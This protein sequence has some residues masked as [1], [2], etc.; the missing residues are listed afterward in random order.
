MTVE[1][2]MKLDMTATTMY[3]DNV[4]NNLNAPIWK[5]LPQEE[6]DFWL[7]EARVSL[8]YEKSGLSKDE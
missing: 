6:R 1:E 2:Q 5:D 8:H 7:E 4:K 3:Y